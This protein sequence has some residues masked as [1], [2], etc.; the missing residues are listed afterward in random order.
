M[1]STEKE[2]KRRPTPEQADRKTLFGRLG[3]ERSALEVRIAVAAK[4]ESDPSALLQLRLELDELNAAI[5]GIEHWRHEEL[6][7]ERH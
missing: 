1:P 3:R 5:K 2:R 7:K 4:L 6:D